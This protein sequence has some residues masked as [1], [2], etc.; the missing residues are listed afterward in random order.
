MI[1]FTVKMKISPRK[2]DLSTYIEI[3]D[4]QRRHLIGYYRLLLEERENLEKRV[5]LRAKE[6][7][8]VDEDKAS[9]R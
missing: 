4:D 3:L 2:Q 6:Q 8:I 1:N 9:R 5:K 7:E